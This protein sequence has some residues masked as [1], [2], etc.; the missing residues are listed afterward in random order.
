M[1]RL[2]GLSAGPQR[3][4]ATFWLVEAPD[5]LAEQSRRSPT[6]PGSG[7]SPRTGRRAS[8]SGRSRPTQTLSSTAEPTK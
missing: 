4:T 7:G 8:T 3:V 1:C 2:F 6:E 5:S